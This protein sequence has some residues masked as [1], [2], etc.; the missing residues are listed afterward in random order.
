M[1]FTVGNF[2]LWT[3]W[4]SSSDFWISSYTNLDTHKKTFKHGSGQIWRL[5]F[6]W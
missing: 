1:T 3:T 4:Y 2:R 5:R 6:A